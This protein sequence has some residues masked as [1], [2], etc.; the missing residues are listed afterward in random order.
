MEKGLS[1]IEK[2]PLE[3]RASAIICIS[4][5]DE[6]PEQAIASVLENQQFFED[7]HI[8]KFGYSS[9]AQLY[10]QWDIDLKELRVLGLD[11]VWHSELDTSKIKTRAPIY[12][13]PDLRVSDGALTAMFADMEYNYNCDHFAVSSITFIELK[14]TRDPRAVLEVMTYGFLLVVLMLDTMRSM[15]SL[16]LYHRTADLRCRLITG[17]WP[18]RVRLAPLRNWVWYAG[19]VPWWLQ[20][21]IS[22]AKSTESAC[23]QLPS[24]KDQ[25]WAFVLR[26]IKTHRY[27]G[28]GIWIAG[29]LFYWFLFSWPFWTPLFN[30][31]SGIGKWMSRDM[32][33]WYW[34]A[35]YGLHTLIVGYVGTSYMQ[36][37][38]RLLPLQVLLY[39]FYL[40][41]SPVVFLY[42]RFHKPRVSW[43]TTAAAAMAERRADAAVVGNQKQA[44][45]PSPRVVKN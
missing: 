28:A 41:V 9:H 1:K 26:T 8:V 32:S 25:G 3:R 37:P 19:W 38:L 21:G 15:I 29:Y 23:M 13:E 33:A 22:T 18:N 44:H 43:D 40:T 35:L 20:S 36:F 6:S 39:T 12:I 4:A 7:V 31:A 34:L 24:Q 45:P 11:P 5:A 14:N 16:G 10:P 30:P 17:T 2:V 42:G 27:M